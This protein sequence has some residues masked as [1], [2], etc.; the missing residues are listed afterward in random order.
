M[1]SANTPETSGVDCR[2]MSISKMIKKRIRLLESHGADDKYLFEDFSFSFPWLKPN[3]RPV[4][5]WT[6]FVLATVA[7][8]LE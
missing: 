4:G 5:V 1:Y 6:A 8:V 7:L 2:D 3:G